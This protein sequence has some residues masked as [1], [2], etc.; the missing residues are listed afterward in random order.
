MHYGDLVN[1]IIRMG[2]VIDVRGLNATN[3]L[4]PNPYQDWWIATG[5]ESWFLA[6]N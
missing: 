1:E 3:P 4:F 6:R 5:H 2:L